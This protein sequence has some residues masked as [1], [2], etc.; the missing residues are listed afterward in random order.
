[1]EQTPKEKLNAML[2]AG[3]A[4]KVNTQKFEFSPL[5]ERFAEEQAAGRTASVD[6]SEDFFNAK[7]PNLA[8][9][10]ERPEHRMVIFLKARGH[11]LQEI[12]AATGYTVPWVSQIVRQPWARAR[13][14]QEINSAGRDELA[15][16]IEGA[17]KE[18][19]YT[20]IELRDD[21]ES[22]ASVR[23]NVS[24]YL[25]DRFL[26]KPKQS[27]EQKVGELKE[28]SDEQL[29]T[30]ATGG[31]GTGTTPTTGSTVVVK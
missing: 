7:D 4:P 12:A 1:M 10:T 26:G 27:I 14:A 9:M 19:M 18:A 16:V 6:A 29:L 21:T 15:T 5:R 3:D 2:T 11:T 22:P 23:A 30:I 31:S 25:V 17:A 24:Q 13:I 20:L 28:V 8:I